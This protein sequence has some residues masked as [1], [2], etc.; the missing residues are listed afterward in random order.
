MYVRC[1]SAYGDEEVVL[2]N[3]QRNNTLVSVDRFNAELQARINPPVPG[4]MEIRIGKTVFREGDKVME[5][6]NTET[7]PKNGDIG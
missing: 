3:P 1:V 4:K 5:L 2:L 6:K 7:G